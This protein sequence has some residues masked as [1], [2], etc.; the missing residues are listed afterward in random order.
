MGIRASRTLGV[1]K[2]QPVEIFFLNQ[3]T[4]NL[5]NTTNVNFKFRK[6]TLYLFPMA[7]MLL[8]QSNINTDIFIIALTKHYSRNKNNYTNYSFKYPLLQKS[9]ANSCLH[10]LW[11]FSC[12]DHCHD[13][14]NWNSQN[15]YWKFNLFNITQIT[16]IF[17]ADCT[18]DLIFIIILESIFW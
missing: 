13:T 17:H 18:R 7:I 1:T 3:T 15:Q 8:M 4:L 10:L 9:A 2:T 16:M 11:T 12:N 5:L 6:T 14:A